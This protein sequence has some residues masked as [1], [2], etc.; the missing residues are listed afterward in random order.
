[1]NTSKNRLCLATYNVWNSNEGMPYRLECLV[2]EITKISPDILCLQE[3][4]DKAMAGL[5]ADT[6]GMNLYFVSYENEEEGICVLSKYPIIEK[7]DWININAQYVTIKC[8]SKTFGIVNLHLPWDSVIK[9]EKHISSIVSKL[10]EKRCDYVFL[11]GDFNSGNHSDVFRMIMGECS[12]YEKEANPCFYDL[13]LASAQLNDATVKNTL[14][15]LNNP[16]FQNNTIEINQR[17]DRIFL[18]NTYPGKFPRL[19]NCDIFGTKIY[20]EINLSASDHYGVYAVMESEESN[21]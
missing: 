10:A 4:K 13:A 3:V 7:E 21:E 5:I 2:K 18:R 11:V 14:N 20:P 8:N 19:I 17:F 12:L 6:L 16:R 15:F 9:R 1:M